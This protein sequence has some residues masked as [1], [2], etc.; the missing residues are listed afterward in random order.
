MDVFAGIWILDHMQSC[1][2]KGSSLTSDWFVGRRGF[3]NF[4]DEAYVECMKACE[5][6]VESGSWTKMSACFN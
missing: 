6:W 3:G 2:N 5:D 1:P 4:R